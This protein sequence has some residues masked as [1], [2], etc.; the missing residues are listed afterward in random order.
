MAKKDAGTGAAVVVL[1]G[2]LGLIILIGVILLMMWKQPDIEHSPSQVSGMY[3]SAAS[4]SSPDMP[5]L[6]G[7]EALIQRHN[8]L[9]SEM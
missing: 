4:E 3:P 8:A 7:S 1:L 2:V 9:R 6:P 5:V